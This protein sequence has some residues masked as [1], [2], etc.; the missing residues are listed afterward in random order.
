MVRGGCR[1]VTTIYIIR[2]S[3]LLILHLRIVWFAVLVDLVKEEVEGFQAEEDE[4][5]GGGGEDVQ[6]ASAGQTD[7]R[8]DPYAGSGGQSAHGILLEDDGT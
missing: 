7:G 3:F 1:L 5:S 4:G 6:A 2:W 8:R